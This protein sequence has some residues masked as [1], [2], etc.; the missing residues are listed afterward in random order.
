MYFNDYFLTAEEGDFIR[1]THEGRL[2][3]GVVGELGK[4]GLFIWHNT[5]GSAGNYGHKHPTNEYRY[6]WEVSDQDI[7]M[8][9]VLSS[10][11]ELTYKYV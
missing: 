2:I 11:S 9:E 1:Y 4:S 10:E 5:L 3:E 7:G 6:S 8:V